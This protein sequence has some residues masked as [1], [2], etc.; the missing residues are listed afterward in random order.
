VHAG[1]FHYLAK[2]LEAVSFTAA[3]EWALEFAA[4]ERS[5]ENDLPAQLRAKRANERNRPRGAG[6]L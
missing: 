4:R 1:F 6:S 3:L 2:P 5:E